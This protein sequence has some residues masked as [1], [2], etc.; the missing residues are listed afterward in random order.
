MRAPS[1]LVA[2]ALWSPAVWTAGAVVSTTLTAK[3]FDRALPAASVAV[4]VTVV[5]PRANVVPDAG[6][7]SAVPSPSTASVLGGAS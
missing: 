1:A 2:S 6:A 4:Q 3:D 7:Q 5:V